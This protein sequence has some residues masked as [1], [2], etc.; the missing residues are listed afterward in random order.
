MAAPELLA[1]GV[2]ADVIDDMGRW[3]QVDLLRR[4]RNRQQQD[5]AGSA[6]SCTNGFAEGLAKS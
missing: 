5:G 4:L 1:L 6:L 3:P 2:S